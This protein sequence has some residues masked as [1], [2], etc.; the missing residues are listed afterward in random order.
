MPRVA[1]VLLLFSSLLLSVAYSTAVPYDLDIARKALLFS[2]AAYCPNATVME[3][4]CPNCLQLKNDFKVH[5]TFY[6]PKYHGWGYVGYDATNDWIVIAFEGSH[7]LANW[8]A[9][10]KFSKQAP[11]KTLAGAKVH[12]GF[13][14]AYMEV[15]ATM[16]SAV[17]ELRQLY[18]TTPIFATGH[19]LGAALAVL[20]AVDLDIYYHNS[21]LSVGIIYTFGEPR[22]GNLPFAEYF[23]T[24]T[25]DKYRLVH[26][27]D[28]VPSLPPKLLG[29]HHIENE[30]WYDENFSSYK[31]C[32]G[33]EDPTCS[34]SLISWS[35]SDHLT[36]LNHTTGCGDNMM[37]YPMVDRETEYMRAGGRV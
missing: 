22:V 5:A 30:I 14:E 16:A 31:A 1:L 26:Y 18:P 19:S 15:E 34:D 9:N 33:G 29:F 37:T 32:K 12:S 8:I 2:G 24:L 21:F 7:D 17:R 20:A 23:D 27:R 13:Y 25:T 10:L 35:V 3:W 11:F 36:Y 6:G 28:I 4:N